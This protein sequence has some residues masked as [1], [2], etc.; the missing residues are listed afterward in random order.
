MKCVNVLFQEG[1]L[2]ENEVQLSDINKQKSK[3][4]TTILEVIIFFKE[5]IVIQ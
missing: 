3:K 5:G 2:S 4:A 1:E